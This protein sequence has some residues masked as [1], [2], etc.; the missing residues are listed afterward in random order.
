MLIQEEIWLV[1]SFNALWIVYALYSQI[2]QKWAA[3][4]GLEWFG[5]DWEHQWLD[6]VA[7]GHNPGGNQPVQPTR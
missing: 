3:G 6:R 7:I 1:K 2:N 5:A 4:T